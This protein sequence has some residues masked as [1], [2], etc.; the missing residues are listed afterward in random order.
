M[1]LCRWPWRKLVV[2]ADGT[3]VPCCHDYDGSH[4]LGQAGAEGRLIW[5]SP[6]RRRFMLRR[7]ARPESIEMC[8]RCS[9]A[10]PRLGLQRT[11]DLER[12]AEPVAEDA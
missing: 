3:V 8:R 4:P 6:E 11:V 7:I 12:T 9:S 2:L 10:V 5:D 1:R